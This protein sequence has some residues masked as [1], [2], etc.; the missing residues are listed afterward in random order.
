MDPYT[1]S[2]DLSE[3]EFQIMKL[4][5]TGKINKEIADKLKIKPDTIGKHLQHVFRKLK[6]QNRTEA[7]VKF[8]R[9]DGL[10]EQMN[11]N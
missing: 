2:Y 11:L 1:N 8:L 9:I 3:R 10:L 6:V 5:A 4:V 7:T